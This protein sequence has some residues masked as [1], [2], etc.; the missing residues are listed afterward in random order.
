MEVE[1]KP[2]GAGEKGRGRAA[3]A[4]FAF[5]RSKTALFNAR[6]KEHFRFI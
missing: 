3:H 4:F 2:K 6:K 1:K 5:L